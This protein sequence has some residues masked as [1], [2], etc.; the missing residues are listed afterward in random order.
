MATFPLGMAVA[1]PLSGRASDKYGPLY[2]TTGALAICA[3]A[4]FYFSTLTTASSFYQVLPGTLL[5]GIGLGMFQSPNSSS[6]MSSVPRNKLGQAGGINSLIRNVG[7][8]MGIAISVTLFQAWG[9]V[10]KPASE[11]V[12]AFM[13]AYRSVMLVAMTIAIAAAAISLNRKSY[14][15]MGTG[16]PVRPDPESP[17]AAA[18]KEAS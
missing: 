16:S 1:A 14:H 18:R 17:S 7:M 10:A 15:H 12:S 9:G 5:L 11:Q 2:L 4:F 13:S 6:V 3:I 8:I